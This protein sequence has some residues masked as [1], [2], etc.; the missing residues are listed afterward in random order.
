M[1]YRELNKVTIKDKY[2]PPR[3]EDLF[4]CLHRAKHFSALDLTAA[5]NQIRINPEH[6]PRTAI[7]TPFGNFE[8]LVGSFGL[9][10]MPACFQRNLDKILFPYIPSSA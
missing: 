9:C 5:Y 6:V 10:N 2:S 1:D 4:N 3:A 8:Y 7:T